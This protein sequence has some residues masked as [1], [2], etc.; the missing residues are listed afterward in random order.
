MIEF[1]SNGE[2]EEPVDG[3]PIKYCKL[4]QN[5]WQDS[6]DKRPDCSMALKMLKNVDV[7]DV[8]SPELDEDIYDKDIDDYIFKSRRFRSATSLYGGS[9]AVETWINNDNTSNIVTFSQ[10]SQDH[11]NKFLLQQ[12]NLHKGL[13]VNGNTFIHGEEI[14]T[15]N[16]TIISQEVK[17]HAQIYTNLPNN[18][19]DILKNESVSAQILEE[20]DICLHIRLLNIEYKNFEIS[21]KFNRAIEDV[22]KNQE[23]ISI[24]TALQKIFEEYGDYIPTKVVIGGALRIKSAYPKDRMSFLQDI[25]TLKANL[26]WAN[27][28]IFSGKSNIFDKI[29]FDDIFTVEDMDNNQRITSGQE[30]VD[31]MEEFYEHKKGYVIAFKEIIPVYTLLKIDLQQEIIKVCGKFQNINIEHMIVP[32]ITNSLIPENLSIWTKNAPIIY[33]SHW[34][35][36]LYLHYG[37][38]IQQNNI[39]HGLEV[40]ID[41]LEMP[42][43]CLLDKSY[44]YLQQPLNKKE[45]FIQANRI[46][47]DNINVAEIP[48]LAV[49][50]TNS[51]HPIFDNQ[52]KSNEVH[53]FIASE[54][55][56]LT[57]N[58][59]KL[60]PSEKFLNAVDKA[61]NSSYPFRNLKNVFDKFGY[62]CSRSIILGRTFSKIYEYDNDVP[63]ETDEY[64]FNTDQVESE[65]IEEK[66]VK[67]NKNAKKLDTSFFLDFNGDI[68]GSNEI[69]FRLTN[70]EEKQHWKTVTQDLIPLYKILPKDKQNEIESIVSDSYHIV[71]TGN[72]EITHKDQIYVNIQFENPL[73]DNDYEMFGCLIINDKN[74][75]DVM[76]R[77]SLANQYGCRAIIHKPDNKS[78]PSDAQIFWIVLSKGH[79]YFSQHSRDI[80]IAYGKKILTSQLPI[81]IEIPL[82]TWL[83]LWLNSCFLI[84]SFDSKD[85]NKN[86]IIQSKLKEFSETCI[87]VE[88]F[89]YNLNEIQCVMTD[90]TMKW[91]IIDTHNADEKNHIIVDVGGAETFSLSFLDALKSNVNFD[92]HNA[93]KENNGNNLQ[94]EYNGKVGE[95]TEVSGQTL[96]AIQTVGDAITPF[97]PLF[98]M[99][100]NLLDQMLQIYENAKCNTKICVALLDRVEIA[101][102]AVKLLQRK[103]QANE[104][105]FRNQNYYH[106]WVRFVNVL[107]NIRKFAKEITQLKY[108][109]KF[110]NANAVK[111]S[112]EKNI[113][114]FEEVCSDLNFTMAMYN[115]VQREM[116]AK[117]VAEDLEILKKLMN[118]M[119]DEITEIRLAISE[120]NTLITSANILGSQIADA[121]NRG[122]EILMDKSGPLIEEYK[123]PQVDPNE[124]QDPYVSDDNVRGTNKTVRKKIYRGMYVA[125]KKGQ[126]VEHNDG[127]TRN[128][129]NVIDKKHQI[130]LAAL[131]KLGV[132]PFIINFYGVSNVDNGEVMIYD[133]ATYNNLREVYLKYDIEWP[134]KLRF[135]RD[136]FNGLVFLHQCNLYHHDVRCENILVT[137]R[138]EPKISNFELMNMPVKSSEIK[139]LADVIRWLAPERMRKS[140]KRST[141]RYNH[142]CEMYR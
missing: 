1:I 102:T 122:G 104:N 38:I 11:V 5:C 91:C 130:E 113:K 105:N 28:Q 118:G 97:V 24:R 8:I 23:E 69:Y 138:F 136:I 99:V 71:M 101:Q 6:A 58:I 85:L 52:Q 14:L 76:I 88:V 110:I 141:Q 7:K 89:Q 77:F 82:P 90:I 108:F 34:I 42:E 18:P 79:G 131:L 19:F 125:C 36:N 46:K 114:E 16:G 111:D 17:Q 9:T 134:T 74:A 55:I 123:V 133:W 56:K 43:I 20:I 40:A 109:Q 27:D 140:P 139:I 68:V 132:C 117:N 80:K 67:W 96:G 15:E 73:Q 119:K 83:G 25:E 84:T 128:L 29:P 26:Y 31:W 62:F 92:V 49:S 53:C 70:L 47:I 39:R 86:Q 30:L 44:M 75:S 78:I 37:L 35:S 100:T 59:N 60:K 127:T 103:Y 129:Y 51:D 57:F 94:E 120:V 3:T 13:K 50:L 121:Q 41:Y 72:T 142:Q 87:R 61:L 33:L 98:N 95:P 12:W 93:V 48:F 54:K 66:L 137:D 45:A 2:R 4:Y 65:M 112:F 106:A 81:D 107:E 32:Y 115:A 22:L 21:D 10:D 63:L 135:A 116:E 124:L 126:L 64:I